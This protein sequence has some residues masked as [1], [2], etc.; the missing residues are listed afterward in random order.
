[1]VKEI[2]HHGESGGNTTVLYKF[3]HGALEISPRW[4]SHSTMVEF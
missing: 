4:R 3:H 2:L 1:M